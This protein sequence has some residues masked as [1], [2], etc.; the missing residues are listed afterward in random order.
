[1]LSELIINY[2]FRIINLAVL[3]G[4][5]A[6]IFKNKLRAQIED[7]AAEEESYLAGLKQQT[8]A[9][10]MRLHEQNEEKKILEQQASLLKQKLSI[11]NQQFEKE[12]T[13]QQLEQEEIARTIT[14]TLEMQQYHL[15]TLVMIRQSAPQA[16]EQA[17]NALKKH[18]SSE[19]SG[20]AYVTKLISY[21][22]ENSHG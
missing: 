18:Y 20:K 3:I 7:A 13:V 5:A 6:Y 10:Q 4:L 1:M 15:K 17:S 2:A 22:K 11:W 19:Q 8:S 9:L 16:L 21:L 12:K 14:S